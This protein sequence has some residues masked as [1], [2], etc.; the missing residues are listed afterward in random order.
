MYFLLLPLFYSFVQSLIKYF[1]HSLVTLSNPFFFFFFSLL[2]AGNKRLV[3]IFLSTPPTDIIIP[4]LPLH[5]CIT[6]YIFISISL[7]ISY[8]QFQLIHYL[9]T[10]SS[11]AIHTCFFDLIQEHTRD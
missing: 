1:K 3:Q 2:S 5:S 7:T 6:S 4:Y 11:S 10:Q 9:N 8:P